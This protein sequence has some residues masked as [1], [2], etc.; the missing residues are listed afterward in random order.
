MGSM[1]SFG[2]IR[3]KGGMIVI[4]KNEDNDPHK[5]PPMTSERRDSA[6]KDVFPT[7]AAGAHAQP[8]HKPHTLHPS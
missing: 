3:G 6:G 4:F 8:E 7:R 5:H 2:E 1:G